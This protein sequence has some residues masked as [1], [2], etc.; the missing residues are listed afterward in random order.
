MELFEI[1]Q[2]KN[3]GPME[4]GVKGEHLLSENVM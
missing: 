1:V 3:A 2:N 4:A